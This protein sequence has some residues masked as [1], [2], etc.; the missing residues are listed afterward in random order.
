MHKFHKM[1][2][3]AVGVLVKL[4]SGLFD[5]LGNTLCSLQSSKTSKTHTTFIP[6]YVYFLAKSNGN[7]FTLLF[8]MNETKYKIFISELTGGFLNLGLSWLFPPVSTLNA[9]LT[10]CWL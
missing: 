9:K 4:L 7:I 10:G 2:T 6:V 3:L 1:S 5:I 8:C